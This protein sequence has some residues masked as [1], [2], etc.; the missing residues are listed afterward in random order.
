ML[1]PVN[2]SRELDGALRYAL[3]PY[4]VAGDVYADATHAGRGGWSW[5][6]GSAGWMY[7]T[8]L[9]RILGIRRHGDS[10]EID[11]CIPAGWP[12]FTLDLRLGAA[13]YEIGVRNPSHVCRGVAGIEVDGS[14]VR[15]TSIPFVDDGRPHRVI[16]TLGAGADGGAPDPPPSRAASRA[17]LRDASR[18]GM[19]AR[20]TRL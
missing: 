15:G 3:E 10:L 17:S 6:T 16:V 4:V 19:E 14:A 5:Y 7:R 1:N 8:G 11:P 9:E 12:E 13:R 18:A 2:R 20:D